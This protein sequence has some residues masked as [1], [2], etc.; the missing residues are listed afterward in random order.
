MES[1]DKIDPEEIILDLRSILEY[2]RE[3]K[4]KLAIHDGKNFPNTS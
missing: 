2:I 3:I 4:R 1:Y